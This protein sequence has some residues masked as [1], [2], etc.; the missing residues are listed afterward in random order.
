MELNTI[1]P[2]AE[3]EKYMSLYSTE[4]QKLSMNIYDFE[5]FFY[6]KRSENQKCTEVQIHDQDHH[7][8]LTK[9]SVGGDCYDFELNFYN[10]ANCVESNESC[11][12]FTVV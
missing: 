9:C 4:D 2:I 5:K 8:D 7:N 12:S 3:I 10:N 11:G 6:Y 1:W